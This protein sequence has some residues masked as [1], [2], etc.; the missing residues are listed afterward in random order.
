M[1]MFILTVNH[2]RGQEEEWAVELD[3]PSVLV[4]R[5]WSRDTLEPGDAITCH[6]GRST[7][8]MKS[9]TVELPGGQKLRSCEEFRLHDRSPTVAAHMQLHGFDEDGCQQSFFF[10]PGQCQAVAAVDTGFF[11]YAFQVDFHSAG[12]NP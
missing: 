5:G 3:S 7:R 9:A 4:H 1:H 11:E 6:G 8:A 10:E 2:D 12:S